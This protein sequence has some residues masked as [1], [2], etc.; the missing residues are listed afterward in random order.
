MSSGAYLSADRVVSPNVTALF[1]LM[2][3]QNKVGTHHYID[4]TYSDFVVGWVPDRMEQQ[5]WGRPATIVT[6]K[7]GA[8]LIADESGHTIWRVPYVGPGG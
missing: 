1:L 6:A 5:V 7:D 2:L 4:P 3:A 8:L